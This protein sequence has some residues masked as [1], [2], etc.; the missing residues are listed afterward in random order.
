MFPRLT[1]QLR[2]ESEFVATKNSEL[3]AVRSKSRANA[4][5]IGSLETASKFR[6]KEV[7]S[8]K[9]VIA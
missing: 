1:N 4:A 7:V 8:L 6:L 5:K 9:T 2:C 3:V